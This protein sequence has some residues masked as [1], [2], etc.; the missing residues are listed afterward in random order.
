MKL[1]IFCPDQYLAPLL[2]KHLDDPSKSVAGMVVEAIKLYN[3]VEIAMGDNEK[4]ALA[5]VDRTTNARY[6]I[7]LLHVIRPERK[8]IE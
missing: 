7:T 5:V 2:N 3:D 8:E 1:T 4:A 6:G